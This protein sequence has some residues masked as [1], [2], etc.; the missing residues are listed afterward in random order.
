[1]NSMISKLLIKTAIARIANY[2]K[3]K[4]IKR[5]RKAKKQNH[6]KQMI[7]MFGKARCILA[8]LFGSWV[9]YT[10]N[11]KFYECP[12]SEVPEEKPYQK[13]YTDEKVA[14]RYE[15]KLKEKYGYVSVEPV[16]NEQQQ[17]I[18]FVLN[19]KEKLLPG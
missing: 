17:Q 4:I 1:M 7:S 16:Y 18:G 13:F 19:G 11:K 10:G 3:F 6:N 8:K 5:K 12:L 14:K 15:K 9:L 2:K